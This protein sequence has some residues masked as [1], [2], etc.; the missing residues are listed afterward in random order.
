MGADSVI[1]EFLMS[2]GLSA[3]SS[4]SWRSS[5]KRRNGIRLFTPE[6][7]GSVD[8]AY[9]DAHP[10]SDTFEHS[11]KK[12]SEVVPVDNDLS[13]LTVSKTGII[14]VDEGQG[15]ESPIGNVIAELLSILK[16]EAFV[17]E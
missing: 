7:I 3:Q 9:P 10:C 5:D 15:M 13:A 17:V 2:Q 14:R 12:D 16:G 11:R 6:K 1:P 4:R 8:A